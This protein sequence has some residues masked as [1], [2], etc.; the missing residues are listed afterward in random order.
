MAAASLEELLAASPSDTKTLAQLVIAYAQFDPVKAQQLSKR[1][2]PLDHL[3][4]NM[5]VD[6]LES[7]NWVIGSKVVKGKVEPSPG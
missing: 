5:D 6:S 7:S 4:E 2:P 3:T 1:L